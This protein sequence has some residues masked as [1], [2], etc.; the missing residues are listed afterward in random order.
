MLSDTVSDIMYIFRFN[1][2]KYDENSK[3][4]FFKENMWDGKLF[5]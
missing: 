5:S 1:F 4:L 3:I 2:K